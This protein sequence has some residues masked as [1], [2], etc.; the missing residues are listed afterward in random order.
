LDP[1]RRTSVWVEH[2]RTG[3]AVLAGL[4]ER[5]EVLA[6]PWVLGELALG[7]LRR[8]DEVLRLLGQLPQA[9]TATLAEVL[10][11]VGRHA[12]AGSGIGLVDAQL[13]AA[14]RLAG[15]ARLWSRDR[16]V[17][18]AAEGLGVAFVPA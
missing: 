17:A 18:A 2:L 6:H 9:P 15:G 12:L 3:D 8:R 16:R 5:S 7:R 4:L 11:L 1:I 14:T 10:V 13:L